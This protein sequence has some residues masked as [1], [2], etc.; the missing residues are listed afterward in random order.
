M[1]PSTSSEIL[2]PPNCTLSALL[3]ATWIHRVVLFL[4]TIKFFVQRFRVM[5]VVGAPDKHWSLW[6]SKNYIKVNSN[7]AAWYKVDLKNRASFKRKEGYIPSNPFSG[8]NSLLVSGRVHDLSYPA[9]HGP[10]L[11][12]IGLLYLW[13]PGPTTRNYYK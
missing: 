9:L 11:G 13:D 3:A 1:D 6:V 8:V 12:V 7:Q 10:F 5:G 2:Y 4:L